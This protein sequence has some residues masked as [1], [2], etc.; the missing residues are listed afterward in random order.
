MVGP[1][2]AP[3][4]G[5]QTAGQARPWVGWCLCPGHAWSLSHPP[6]SAPLTAP[7]LPQEELWLLCT[8]FDLAFALLAGQVK[9]LTAKVN[10]SR[11]PPKAATAKTPSAQPTPKP[12]AQPPTTPAPTPA[13]HPVPPSFALVEKSP[14][15]P[16]LVMALHPSAPCADVALSAARWTAKNTSWSQLDLTLRCINSHKPHTSFPIPYQ[17]SSPMTPHP[18]LSPHMKMSSGPASLS[19]AS[20]P[21]FLLPMGLTPLLSA[22]RCSWQIT[23]PSGPSTSHSPHLG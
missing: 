3:P 20:P 2:R 17:P 22:S 18:S 8:S 14:A 13:S 23:L 6:S 19:T 5:H 15:W 21:E 7:S 11:P 9:E 10:G 1:C 16:S 4:L 12:H